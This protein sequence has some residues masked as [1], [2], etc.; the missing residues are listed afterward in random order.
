VDHLRQTTPLTLLRKRESR[1]VYDDISFPSKLDAPIQA[2]VAVDE[3]RSVLKELTTGARGA[4]EQAQLGRRD[5]AEEYFVADPTFEVAKCT[6]YAC[7]PTAIQSEE[8]ALDALA[9]LD[10]E[11]LAPVTVNGPVAEYKEELPTKTTKDE[12]QKMT[13]KQLRKLAQD[14]GKM[15]PASLTKQD[16]ITLLL[17]T[18]DT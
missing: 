18:V 5:A 2:F 17:S 9:A 7:A 8:Q 6:G 11:E 4:A 15:V 13:V 10:D 3:D 12:Y 14:S 1:L 16:L